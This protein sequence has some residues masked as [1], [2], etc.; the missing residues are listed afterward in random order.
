[1]NK[2]EPKISNFIKLSKATTI[3]G[4]KKFE[5]FLQNKKPVHIAGTG[6]I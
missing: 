1:L 4:L 2:V 6:F 5:G 3:W